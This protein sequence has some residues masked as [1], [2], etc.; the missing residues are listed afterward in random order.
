MPLPHRSQTAAASPRNGMMVMATIAIRCQ[1]RIRGLTVMTPRMAGVG[2]GAGSG[3]AASWDTGD[4][5]GAGGSCDGCVSYATVGCLATSATGRGPDARRARGGGRYRAPVGRR[6]TPPRPETP[7]PEDPPVPSDVSTVVDH[8][9][10][11][12]HDALD[13]LG[14]RLLGYAGRVEPSAKDDGTPVTDADVEADERL[15]AAIAAAF[16]DHGVLSEER[17]TVAPDTEWCWIVD[18]IDGTSNFTTGLPYWCVSVALTH[19][20][21]VV[22]A[23]VDAPPL[24][25]RA[26]ATRGGG[27]SVDG[28]RTSVREAVDWRDGR[29]RHVPVMLTTGTARRARGAGL[30]LNPRVMG[31]TALD[32][33]QVAAGRAVAS[34]AVIPKVWDVA[35]GGLLVTEAGGTVATLR[36]TPLL[37]LQ[38][39]LDHVDRSATTAAGPS[40]GYLED[41]THGLLPER[42]SGA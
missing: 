34:V 24:G 36:G 11:V 17:D 1:R 39:G 42:S 29:H 25:T 30:R 38:V 32:L 35:A 40:V 6:A 33:L 15:A 10:R 7:R 21:E 26:T 16:P 3:G 4:L 20:G 9:A 28:R 22:L 41:L 13:D 5:S 18:P 19:E 14:P 23:T 31:S 12:L 27:T 8:A 37:P 2:S